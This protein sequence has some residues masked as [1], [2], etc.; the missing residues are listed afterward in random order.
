MAWM[1]GWAKPPD[2]MYSLPDQVTLVPNSGTGEGVPGSPPVGRQGRG[3]PGATAQR[4]AGVDITADY[5]KPQFHED[6]GPGVNNF[7]ATCV[8]S[9]LAG[10]AT[11]AVNPGL[12]EQACWPGAYG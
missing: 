9:L 2:L 11:Y 7:T 5:G 4:H 8:H 6:E 3:P 12:S 1:G 10:F